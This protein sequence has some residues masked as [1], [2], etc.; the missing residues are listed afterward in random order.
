VSHVEADTGR[1]PSAEYADVYTE[2][3][4]YDLAHDP[5]ELENLITKDSHS[6]VRA[7]MRGL[8]LDRIRTVEGRTPE[9]QEPALRPG[10]QRIVTSDEV[11]A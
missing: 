1:R 7:R 4:L 8:L 5:Y 9:I 2:T 11:L 10:G 3:E 6:A